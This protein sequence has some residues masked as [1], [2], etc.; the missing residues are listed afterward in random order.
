MIGAQDGFIQEN[1]DVNLY[2]P[3]LALQ[4]Q[5]IRDVIGSKDTQ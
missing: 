5:G 4:L 1:Y 3:K 2:I